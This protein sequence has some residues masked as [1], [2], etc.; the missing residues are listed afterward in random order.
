MLFGLSGGS[1]FEPSRT[2]Y[3]VPTALPPSNCPGTACGCCLICSY[4]LCASTGNHS[5]GSVW[6]D[7]WCPVNTRIQ[8]ISQGSQIGF[9]N[10]NRYSHGLASMPVGG[11]PASSGLQSRLASGNKSPA[12]PIMVHGRSWPLPWAHVHLAAR[13]PSVWPKLVD[14]NTSIQ[15]HISRLYYATCYHFCNASFSSVSGGSAVYLE[16]VLRIR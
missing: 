12:K 1:I 3:L 5:P 6:R 4:R 16:L 9:S 14:F 13:Y 2:N 10:S 7:A 11:I 8:L 15:G